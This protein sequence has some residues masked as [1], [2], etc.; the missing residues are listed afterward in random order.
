[1][2]GGWV[3]RHCGPKVLVDCMCG[4]GGPKVF[5]GL[6]ECGCGGLK[7]L[8]AEELCVWGEVLISIQ[9][10]CVI[11]NEVASTG[12]AACEGEQ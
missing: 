5:G 8:G 11:G 6:H 10:C 9:E 7:V 2:E 4:N 12:E 1:M 3:W